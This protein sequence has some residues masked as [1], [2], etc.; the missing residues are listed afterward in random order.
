M[1]G[2]RAR[3]D[4]IWD[5]GGLRSEGLQKGDRFV[6]KGGMFK[7]YEAISGARLSGKEYMRLLLRMMGDRFVSIE[8]DMAM[9]EMED[10]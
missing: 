4:D 3:L 7:G 8:V 1:R 9:L 6:L 10:R 5:T 2:L